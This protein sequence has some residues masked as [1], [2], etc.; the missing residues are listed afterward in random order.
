MLFEVGKASDIPP[1]EARRFV[2]DRIEIA[3]ANCD[4]EFLAVDDICSHAEYSLSDGE[5]DPD[6]CTIECPKHGSTFDL[7]TGRPR[8]LPATVPVA[9]FPVKVEGDTLLIE[10]EDR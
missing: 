4:G 2:V 1:G 8:T 7:H 9:T 5:V 3:V 6:D 10:L